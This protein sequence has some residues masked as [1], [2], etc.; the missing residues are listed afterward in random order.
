MSTEVNLFFYTIFTNNPPINNCEIEPVIQDSSKQLI[1]ELIE[2]LVFKIEKLKKNCSLYSEKLT[3]KLL[4]E[5]LVFIPKP[6]PLFS[7]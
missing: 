3:V 1:V 2:N 6:S 4:I 7:E 5:Y